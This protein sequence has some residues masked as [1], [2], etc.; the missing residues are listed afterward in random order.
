VSEG[1]LNDDEGRFLLDLARH[2][3]GQALDSDT[4]P[5]PSP[6]SERLREPGASF[7][8][9]TTRD[10]ALRG[11]IGSLVARRPLVEDVHANALAAAFEDPRFS[12]LKKE[13][14]PHV[15]VEI[16][17][18]TQ[19]EPLNYSDTQDLVDRLRPHV[20]GVVIQRGWHRA[21]FLP[22]V[23]DQLPMI[24]EFLSHLCY[25]AGL[26]AKAW[27]EGN[28]EVSIYRVQKFEEES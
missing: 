5:P 10:G 8:T 25:K 14:L 24:E 19:P 13:E 11:C 4:T 16:S 15:K 7:V 18:L 9:L 27:Q 21:T 26:P 17:V 1:Y 28:L 12:P 3:I 20:D 2:T 6:S 22:Q 23:W